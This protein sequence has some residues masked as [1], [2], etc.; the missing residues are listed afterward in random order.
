[1]L[2]EIQSWVVE[3]HASTVIAFLG[4]LV[5][6]ALA[7]YA[8]GITR[9]GEKVQEALEDIGIKFHEDNR[10]VTIHEPAEDKVVV[11]IT[12][13]DEEIELTQFDPADQTWLDVP[14]G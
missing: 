13:D 12:W 10:T 6:A 8:S 4:V 7:G 14:E 3:V 5:G 1:M 2:E 11:R 9:G